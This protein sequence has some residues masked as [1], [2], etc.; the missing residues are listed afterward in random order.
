MA[1]GT[2]TWTHGSTR[3]P[4]RVSSSVDRW[5]LVAL[6]PGQP[7]ARFSIGTW[8]TGHTSQPGG[9]NY[10]AVQDRVVGGGSCMMF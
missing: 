3:G 6:D 9:V 4:L 2:G 10:K 1:W 8:S 7:S 5:P